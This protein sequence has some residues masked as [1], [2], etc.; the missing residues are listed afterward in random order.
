MPQNYEMISKNGNE[1]NKQNL[2]ETRDY[3]FDK[4]LI[5]K[6]DNR[7]QMSTNEFTNLEIR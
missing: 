4:D 7:Q 2:N 3:T 6:N 1:L 5:M